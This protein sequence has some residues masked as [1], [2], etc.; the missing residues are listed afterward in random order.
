[1]M[2]Y[3]V[4]DPENIKQWDVF[5]TLTTGERCRIFKAWKKKEDAERE[6]NRLPEGKVSPVFGWK[7]IKTEYPTCP[8]CGRQG[9]SKGIREHNYNGGGEY[10]Y[11][12]NP[13]CKHEWCWS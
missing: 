13:D 1:M 8:K 12:L 5:F 6:A 7:T 4:R 3:E 10:F 9:K 2:S 11:C